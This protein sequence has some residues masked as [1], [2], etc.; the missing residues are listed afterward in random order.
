MYLCLIFKKTGVFFSGFFDTNVF[1]D[2]IARR[3]RVLRERKIFVPLLLK[4]NYLF[5]YCLWPI[6]LMSAISQCWIVD[7][8]PS[9]CRI[10]GVRISA[11][12]FYIVHGM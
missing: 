2:N 5:C 9:H 3:L 12:C 7:S 1:V 11:D 4:T 6:I 8:A 10:E